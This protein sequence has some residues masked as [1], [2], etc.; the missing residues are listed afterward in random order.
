MKSVNEMRCILYLAGGDE[1]RV[2]ALEHA[3]REG[4]VVLDVYESSALPAL[5]RRVCEQRDADIIVVA[6]I[7]RKRVAELSAYAARRGVEVRVAAQPIGCAVDG[8]AESEVD[9]ASVRIRE[10]YQHVV[11]AF[12]LRPS[13]S[14][15]ARDRPMVARR[16]GR[17]PGAKD[18]KP[19]VRRYW[20]KPKEG[21]M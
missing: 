15:R 11:G 5:M 17:P 6:G 14:W 16:W 21:G 20:K 9:Y 1:A 10:S 19:R 7:E 18:K 8:F 2:T 12:G 13:V 3:R 4:L